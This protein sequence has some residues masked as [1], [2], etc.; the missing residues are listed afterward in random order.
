MIY[1]MGRC[2]LLGN[3][4]WT[5]TD[6]NFQIVYGVPILINYNVGMQRPMTYIIMYNKE[7]HRTH[8]R[9]LV[10]SI[11]LSRLV[12][13]VYNESRKL[14]ECQQSPNAGAPVDFESRGK[15]PL[16]PASIHPGRWSV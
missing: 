4:K 16:S 15:R 5:G 2:G 11:F 8:C 13:H 12:L 3:S 7:V 10:I 9:G 14:I 6:M 1:C